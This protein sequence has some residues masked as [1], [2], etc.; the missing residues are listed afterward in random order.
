MQFTKLLNKKLN[1][2]VRA[3][4]QDASGQVFETWTSV[5]L[6]VPCRKDIAPKDYQITDTLYKNTT[7]KY[8]FFVDK[9][10]YTAVS[11]LNH[12]EC[13]GIQ[14]AVLDVMRFDSTATLHHIEIYAVKAELGNGAGLGVAPI[15]PSTFVRKTQKVNEKALVGDITIEV[16]DIPNLTTELASIQTELDTKQNIATN[17]DDK[18][19]QQNFTAQSVI[20]VNHNLSK[21]PSVTILD[22]TGDEIVGSIQHISTNQFVVTL[23]A[24]TGGTVYCN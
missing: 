3:T 20:T 18:T 7:E 12:V 2:L 6:N 10:Y 1:I 23:S 22:S 11:R 4:T 9:K 13:E 21:Y 17:Y 16:A 8:T 5:T 14:Y 24:S 15:D 19:Y